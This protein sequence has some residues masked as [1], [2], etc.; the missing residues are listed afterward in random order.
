L[1]EK[2]K[3]KKSLVE[4][5]DGKFGPTSWPAGRHH[6]SWDTSHHHRCLLDGVKS[7]SLFCMT[8]T[9]RLLS[10]GTQ[11]RASTAAFLKFHLQNNQKHTFGYFN[12]T[13]F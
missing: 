5:V 9:G 13:P 10:V 7:N 12:S 1:E 8:P 11:L 2:K 4:V 3:K 6:Y